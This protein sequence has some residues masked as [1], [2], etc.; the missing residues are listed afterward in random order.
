MR[1]VEAVQGV[2]VRARPV[3]R[4]GAR[5]LGEDVEGIVVA[6]DGQRPVPLPVPRDQTQRVIAHPVHTRSLHGDGNTGE[7][8]L[9][10][11]RTVHGVTVEASR[12]V[13]P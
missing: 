13:V 7:A 3:R 9:E 8:A 5:R 6:G 12:G 10:D 11:L 2:D 1:D 4:D